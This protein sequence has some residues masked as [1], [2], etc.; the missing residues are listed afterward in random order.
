MP[1]AVLQGFKDRADVRLG[2]LIFN[3]FDQN[4]V[5]WVVT[6]IPGWWEFPD[7]LLPDDPKPYELDGSYTTPGRFNARTM[8]LNG[9]IVPPAGV[10]WWVGLGMP[11]PNFAAWARE[12]MGAGLSDLVRG[13]AVLRVD[14]DFPKQAE[15]Q[16]NGNVTMKNSTLNGVLEFSIPL[17]AADPRKYSQAVFSLGG[18]SGTTATGTT[19]PT[20]YPISYT[21]GSTSGS[22]G[23]VNGGT[24]NTG[25]I[26]K[27]YGPVTNPTIQHV[28]SG[29]TMTFVDT[30]ADGD[31]YEINLIDRLIMLNGTV[32]R[33]SRLALGSRWFL[34]DPGP[35]TILYNG[36]DITTV[37]TSQL[38]IEYRYAWIY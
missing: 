18:T 15:V 23:I 12:R 30:I 11:T 5:A 37:S 29:H 20:T 17:K 13:T 27:I 4:D 38:T 22:T 32:S 25:A 10:Q 2:E 16:L 26:I 34:L 14:E 9:V 31:Y 6:D 33:R 3:A 24:Y 19:Y 8:S 7:I 35:N 28:Q 36:T 21:A 1:K